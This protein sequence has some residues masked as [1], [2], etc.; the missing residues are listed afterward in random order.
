MCLALILLEFLT[1][2]LRLFCHNTARNTSLLLRE[3]NHPL[4][5]VE[6]YHT[7]FY[8]LSLFS[9]YVVNFG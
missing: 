5:V 1:Y 4:C 9:A 6:V 3:R 2:S 8:Y 7:R